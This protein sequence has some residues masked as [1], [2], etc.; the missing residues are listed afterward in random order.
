MNR[1]LDKRTSALWSKMQTRNQEASKAKR[2]GGSVAAQTVAR[3]SKATCNL[4]IKRAQTEL[5]LQETILN[6]QRQNKRATIIKVKEPDIV[7]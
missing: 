6:E 5:S 1:D 2:N 7:H 4:D 3:N